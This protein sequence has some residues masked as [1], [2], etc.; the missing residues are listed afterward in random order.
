M[1]DNNY[2]SLERAGRICEL[3]GLELVRKRKRAKK[4]ATKTGMS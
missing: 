3:L 2:L 1:S 4:R